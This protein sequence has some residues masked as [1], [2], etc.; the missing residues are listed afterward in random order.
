LCVEIAVRAMNMKRCPTCGTQLQ[1]SSASCFSC[2]AVLESRPRGFT[3]KTSNKRST[4]QKDPIKRYRRF[5]MVAAV[6]LCVLH[7]CDGTPRALAWKEDVQYHGDDLVTVRRYESYTSNLELGGLMRNVWIND[8]SI[9]WLGGDATYPGPLFLKKELPIRLGF[10]PALKAWYVITFVE[11][12]YRAKTLGLGERPYF[13]YRW[14][15]NKW[16]RMPIPESRVRL[17]ANL[18]LTKEEARSSRHIHVARKKLLDSS[19][20]RPFFLRVIEDRI[21]C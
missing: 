4:P 1:E 12:C 20:A 7:L 15:Q 21:A 9:E 19:N 10:D 8:S 13:E 18:L 11:D 2:G 5:A 6:L 14:M 17:S 3:N 16:S